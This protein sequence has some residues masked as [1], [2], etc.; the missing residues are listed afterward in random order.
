MVLA[1]RLGPATFGQLAVAFL[2]CRYAGMVGDWG[3]SVGGARDVAA[4]A[5]PSYLR[6][7]VR[8]RELVTGALCGSYL[9]AVFAL[10]HQFL[11]PLA[12]AIVSRGLSRDW[13][14]LGRERG[15]RA[16]APA[17]VQGGVMLSGALFAGSPEAATLAIAAGYGFAFLASLRLNPLP[18]VRSGLPSRVGVSPWIL[19]VVLADQV[20][21]SVDIVLLGALRSSGEAG[22][23]AAVYRIPNAVLTVVG[24]IVLGLVP[25]AART[26]RERPH[27]FPAARQRALRAGR[28]WASV[29]ALTIV[30]FSFVMPVLFGPAYLPGRTPLV[31]LLLAAAVTAAAAPLQPIYF[32]LAKDKELAAIVGVVAASNF[33]ANLVAITLWGATG[34]A[35]TT[36]A[37]QVLLLLLYRRCLR[38]ATAG[39]RCDPS[40]RPT[41][42]TVRCAG[43][44]STVRSG[45]RGS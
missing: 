39:E 24:L 10:G 40:R 28:L 8:R 13:M 41:S 36:L 43:R 35:S 32:A 34:A 37:G 12:F 7:L 2:V 1:R 22:V 23:Y 9:V 42:S 20:I 6:A 31:L 3:A 33:A 25:T 4:S 21:A 29:V 45:S 19:V 18:A 14:A 15:W 5:D 26:L 30:P 38:D 17:V 27:E 44:R 11:A 16:G